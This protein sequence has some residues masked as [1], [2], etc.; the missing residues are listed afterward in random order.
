[1]T[2]FDVG[3]S[4]SFDVGGDDANDKGLTWSVDAEGH[5][6][7]TMPKGAPRVQTVVVEYEEGARVCRREGEEGTSSSTAV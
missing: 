7:L 3:G 1:M 4:D 2:S 5:R 6:V